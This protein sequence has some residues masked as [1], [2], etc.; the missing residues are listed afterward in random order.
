[1][2]A[3]F[4]SRAASAPAQPI[5][6]P[7][8]FGAREED[9]AHYI[10][11]DDLVDAVNT[12][13]LLGRPLLVT[14]EPGTG[15]TQLAR[16]VAFQLG[17]GEPLDF[18]AK[19]T[20][21]AQELFYSFDAVGRL[22]SGDGASSARAGDS[23]ARA[24]LQTQ[25]FIHYQA[26]GKAILFAQE[27]SSVRQYMPSAMAHGGRRRS[28]VLVD[29]IDKAPRDFPNDMLS[30]LER[31]DFWVPELDVHLRAPREMRPVVIITSNSERGL[32]DAFLRRCIYFDIPFPSTQRLHEI[33]EARLATSYD[34]E[35]AAAA[36]EL[37]EQL[38]GIDGLRLTKRPSTA[39]L[40][41]FML[42]L[43]RGRSPGADKVANPLVRR[44]V[45][46]T[47]IGAL[48]KTREDRKAGL[49]VLEAWI[50]RAP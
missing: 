15:K 25:E 50:S 10:A 35:F 26:L 37:L 2:S 13:L 46:R 40:I 29:E 47:A 27:E 31:M 20:S 39:E 22:R 33:L 14:G 34:R 18:V 44:S 42:A 11:D 16:N 4:R 1:M 5:E 17:Y 36:L 12:A 7:T 43:L 3:I 49:P 6:L 28:V 9:P 21:Q 19:S 24:P 32:P 48:L 8:P 23:A 38:R 45:A 41:G 30:E